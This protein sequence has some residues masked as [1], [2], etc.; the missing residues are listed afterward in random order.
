MAACSDCEGTGCDTRDGKNGAEIRTCS[1]C[2]GSG[3]R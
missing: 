2:G 1:A 3:R